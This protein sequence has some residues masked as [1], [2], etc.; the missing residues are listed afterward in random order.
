MNKNEKIIIGLVGELG[1]GKG[2]VV[3]YLK[4]KY[5]AVS[6][7]FS[8]ML[9]D[10]LQRLYLPVSRENLQQISTALRE[11]FGADIMAKIVAE[12]VLDLNEKMIVVDGVRRFADIKYVKTNKNF[13]L[14]AVSADEKIRFERYVRR[15]E[16]EGDDKINFNDFLKMQKREADAEI[17]VVIKTAKYKIDN[18]GSLDDLFK[19]V[20]KILKEINR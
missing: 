3:K 13:I 7:R 11:Y 1:A 5:G 20:D 18:S 16:K 15:N 6:I 8:D 14:V 2:T 10:V 19:Q 17:P 12:D 9:R 4:E